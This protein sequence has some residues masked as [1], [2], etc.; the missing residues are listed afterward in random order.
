MSTKTLTVI[1]ALLLA[2]IADCGCR[3]DSAGGG[4]AQAEGESELA[5][6]R[7]EKAQRDPTDAADRSTSRAADASTGRRMHILRDVEYAAIYLYAGET[8]DVTLRT[9][10]KMRIRIF[11]VGPRRMPATLTVTDTAERTFRATHD[12]IYALEATPMSDGTRGGY[13]LRAG[14]SHDGRPA[15]SISTEDCS[16][17]DFMAHT[18]ENLHTENVFREPRRIV[19]RGNLKSFFSGSSRA[20]VPVPVPQGADA[21]V[22]SLRISSNENTVDSDGKLADNLGSGY[23]KVKLLGVPVYERSSGFDL[24][25][26]LLDRR[27]PREEDAF[28]SLYVL[29]GTKGVRKFQDHTGGPSTF[30]YDERHSQVGTQSCVGQ[31][32]VNGV[33]DIYLGFENERMRYDTFVWL[34]VVAVSR[35]KTHTRPVFTLRQRPM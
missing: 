16:A 35:A 9:R 1:A 15:V 13:M 22:Y 17:S 27:P 23:K 11:D 31:I 33:R 2:L 20:V 18:A 12:G 34:E 3:S 5:R 32:P 4:C 24:G 30:P 7:R 29:K 26:L 19:L 25:G 6:M 14:G 28:V 8:L 21:I 10:G